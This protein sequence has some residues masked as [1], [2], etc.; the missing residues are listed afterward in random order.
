MYNKT[1]AYKS[2]KC[3]KIKQVISVKLPRVPDS[4]V[5]CNKDLRLGL[6]AHAD[7]ITR[8]DKII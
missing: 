8:K 2:G 7:K 1:W 3:V 4:N 5:V 6:W